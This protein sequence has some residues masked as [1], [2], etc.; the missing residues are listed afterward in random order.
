MGDH[1]LSKLQQVQ[2]LPHQPASGALQ[3]S[4]TNRERNKT[5]ESR[6]RAGDRGYLPP[7]LPEIMVI[8]C[9]HYAER[10]M[11]MPAS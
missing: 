6:R 8:F 10:R 4:A 1:L 3:D 9:P 5:P 11:G 2:A 7:A